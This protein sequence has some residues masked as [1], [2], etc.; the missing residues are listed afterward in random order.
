MSKFLTQKKLI[1]IFGAIVIIALFQTCIRYEYHII[2]KGMATVR[3][4]R[5]TGK[6]KT[7]PNIEFKNE[8]L[9]NVDTN[10]PNSLLYGYK[11]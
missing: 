8:P 2:S 4:D 11:E 3:I 7:I 10:S 5:L 9:Y 1:F 6:I